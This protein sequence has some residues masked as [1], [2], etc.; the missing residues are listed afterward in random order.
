MKALGNEFEC[1]VL[2]FASAN[3]FGKLAFASKTAFFC[4]E[5]AKLGQP[6]KGI[7]LLD[8]RRVKNMPLPTDEKGS[9]VNTIKWK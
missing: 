4:R 2:A 8:L 5:P 7:A 9:F 3:D 6:P 1:P